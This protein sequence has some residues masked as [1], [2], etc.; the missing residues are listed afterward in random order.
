M[1]EFSDSKIVIML[2]MRYNLADYRHIV[3][4]NYLNALTFGI[5]EDFI[6][7]RVQAGYCTGGKY[8]FSCDQSDQ[9]I[10]VGKGVLWGASPT[11]RNSSS[12]GCP[13][14]AD[15]CRQSQTSGSFLEV[16]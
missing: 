15:D 3:C 6:L 13:R 5:S 10:W 16:R 4:G 9:V 14:T 12:I 2:V 11:T 7:Y 8:Q 1:N